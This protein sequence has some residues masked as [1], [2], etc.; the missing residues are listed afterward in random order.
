MTH[1][2]CRWSCSQSWAS[3]SRAASSEGVSTIRL[4]E[5]RPLKR[6]QPPFVVPIAVVR[7]RVRPFP[8]ADL[9]DQPGTELLEVDDPRVVQRD[10]DAERAALPRLGEDEL[11]VRAR[12]RSGRA[13]RDEAGIDAAHAGKDGTPVPIMLSRVTSAAS[14]SSS[15]PSVPAGRSGRTR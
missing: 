15:I 14:L 8:V 7:G 10:G 2:Q 9:P 1:R 6:G 4:G 11:A 12:G 3:A 13:R 5:Q